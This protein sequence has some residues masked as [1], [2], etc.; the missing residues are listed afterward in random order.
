MT[1]PQTMAW[2]AS[3]YA[4]SF[5]DVPATEAQVRSRWPGAEAEDAE[6]GVWLL[7]LTYDEFAA[8]QLGEPV[9]LPDGTPVWLDVPMP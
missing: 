8:S 2:S 5:P 9:R 4:S 3:V 1:E 6:A 7:D